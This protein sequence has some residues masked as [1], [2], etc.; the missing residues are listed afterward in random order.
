MFK[1]NGIKFDGN[2]NF[3]RN[4]E[5]LLEEQKD[6]AFKLYAVEDEL[7]GVN[8]YNFLVDRFEKADSSEQ[9]NIVYAF[10]NLGSNCSLLEGQTTD[11][12]FK[13]SIN[14]SYGSKL[15]NALKTKG[16]H[17]AMSLEKEY[18]ENSPQGQRLTKVISRLQ[19]TIS[20]PD[21]PLELKKQFIYGISNLGVGEV[22]KNLIQILRTT[23]SSNQFLKETAFIELLQ[24]ASLD[25][26]DIINKMNEELSK[27]DVDQY[28]I[29]FLLQAAEKLGDE[30]TVNI[31]EKIKGRQD[32]SIRARIDILI[33]KLKEGK[34]DKNQ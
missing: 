16:L 3:S 18:H 31:L 15:I 11:F 8:I 26:K 32:E 33:V 22:R 7:E 9:E 4:W 13:L 24:L 14:D 12:L 6:T 5:S 27:G 30:S 29:P 28:E 34:N 17:A 25:D 20:D 10:E 21:V 2:Q 19:E 1:D 23:E